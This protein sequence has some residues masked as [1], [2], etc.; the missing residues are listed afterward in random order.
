MRAGDPRWCLI[1]SEKTCVGYFHV[2]EA[3]GIRSEAVVG[4][5]R[6][7]PG[8]ESLV[9]RRLLAEDNLL[10]GAVPYELPGFEQQAEDRVRATGKLTRLD[11]A[12]GPSELMVGAE[13]AFGRIYSTVFSQCLCSMTRLVLSYY[14]AERADIVYVSARDQ[15]RLPGEPAVV[16]R[17]NH[18]LEWSGLLTPSSSS[19][20][21]V[22][23]HKQFRRTGYLLHSHLIAPVLWD[24]PLSDMAVTESD[25]RTAVFGQ[26]LADTLQSVRGVL[27]RGEGVWVFGASIEGV[28]KAVLEC[29]NDAF[30]AL[31][32]E[33]S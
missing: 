2:P 4:P 7:W 12:H 1:P 11:D 28:I 15:P 24:A 31:W 33:I 10:A 3:Q 8:Q 17:M 27:R 14:C 21:H 18:N 20:S 22:A 26:E 32:N 6:C 16:V 30:N 9:S 13:Q 23:F 19:V 25:A 29:Q 5:V